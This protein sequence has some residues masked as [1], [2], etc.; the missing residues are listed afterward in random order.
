L[1]DRTTAKT[2]TAGF[3]R[4]DGQEAAGAAKPTVKP[5]TARQKKA[6]GFIGP[7]GYDLR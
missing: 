1:T 2:S 7:S 6:P 5:S 3:V 4:F